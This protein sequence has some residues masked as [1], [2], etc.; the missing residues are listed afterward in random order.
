MDFETKEGFSSKFQT[1]KWEGK[2][3]WGN[4][5]EDPS[6]EAPKM[7]GCYRVVNPQHRRVMKYYE[8]S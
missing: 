3:D 6:S 1:G 5:S 7:M 8:I 4:Y 2:Q